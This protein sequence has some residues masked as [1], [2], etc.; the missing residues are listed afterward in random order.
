MQI[1]RTK[2]AP[3]QFYRFSLRLGLQDPITWKQAYVI[4]TALGTVALWC[5]NSALD[6]YV[7]QMGIVAIIPM[8]FYFGFGLLNKASPPTL[9]GR[10]M[11]IARRRPLHCNI[12]QCMHLCHD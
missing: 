10:R 12:L 1:L 2:V 4:F 6:K 11:L 5:A 7:G 3:V 9:P 8:V